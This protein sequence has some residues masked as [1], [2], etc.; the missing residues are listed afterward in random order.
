LG[1]TAPEGS[2]TVPDTGD[3]DCAATDAAMMLHKSNKMESF[4]PDTCGTLAW[5][6]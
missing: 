3:E 1:M 5:E 4:G 2:C 6:S